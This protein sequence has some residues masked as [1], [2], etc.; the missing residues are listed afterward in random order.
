M[1]V[2][3]QIL[4]LARWAPSGDNTQPWRFEV[5]ADDHVVVHGHDTREDIVYDLDGHASQIAIGAL[6]Q[7][8]EIAASRFRQAVQITRRTYTPDTRP[9]F[10]V[11][12]AADANIVES[13]LVDSIKVRATQR[14]PMSMRRLGD[15]EKAALEHAAAPGFEIHWWETWSDRWRLA[16]FLFQNARLRLITPEAFKVHSSIVD[17]NAQFSTERIPDQALGLNPLAVRLTRWTFSDWSRMRLLNGIP[18]ATLAPRLELDFVPALA[19]AAHHALLAKSV[20]KSVD[21]YIEAGKA[22]QRVWLTLSRLGLWQQPEM[23]P[24]IFSGYARNGIAFTGN[25]QAQCL[26]D[27]I[28]TQFDELLPSRRN[29]DAVW[30]GRIGAGHAPSARSI[31]RELAELLIPGQS[32]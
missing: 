20:P 27:E 30:M 32:T 15:A 18:G 13:D 10:D 19:C 26:A 4:D 16:R 5:R 7:T 31:R 21:D 24:L 25:L 2:I 12:L 22:V 23:T 14:R 29:Q 3:E 17:W 6:L 11:R 28:R 9:T 1:R 8:I